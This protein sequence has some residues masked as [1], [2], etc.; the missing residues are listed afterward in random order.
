MLTC[1]A[2]TYSVFCSD[3]AKVT[4]ISVV[5]VFFRHMSIGT[6][7]LSC[8]LYTHKLCNLFF[9]NNLSFFLININPFPKEH[10]QTYFIMHT[11]GVLFQCENYIFLK[12]SFVSFFKIF[13]TLRLNSYY[14][15]VSIVLRTYIFYLSSFYNYSGNTRSAQ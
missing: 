9:F 6:S 14:F 10:E 1:M 3:N 11:D 13:I 5:T 15:Q 7:L 12:C 4:H 2:T 8:V